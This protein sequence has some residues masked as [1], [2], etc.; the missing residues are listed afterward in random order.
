MERRILIAERRNAL[1]FYIFIWNC[2]Y[3]YIW[4]C[5]LYKFSSSKIIGLH[6]STPHHILK[7]LLYINPDQVWCQF[8]S[9]SQCNQFQGC[10]IYISFSRVCITFQLGFLVIHLLL[11]PIP[12]IRARDIRYWERKNLKRG[13][14]DPGKSF[15]IPFTINERDKERFSWVHFTSILPY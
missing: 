2:L 13:K 14:V 15:F 6:S 9:K 7:E 10:I 11:F 1:K 3:I 4:K 8:Y 12:T 5:L